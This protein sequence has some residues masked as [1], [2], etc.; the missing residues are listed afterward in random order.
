MLTG[1][2]H[3]AGRT[4]T[5][6]HLQCICLTLYIL[7]RAAVTSLSLLPTLQQSLSKLYCCCKLLE[8]GMVFCYCPYITGCICYSV[9]ACEAKFGRKS[10]LPWAETQLSVGDSQGGVLHILLPV[11][12][13]QDF[14]TG[15]P[16]SVC[17]WMGELMRASMQQCLFFIYVYVYPCANCRRECTLQLRFIITKLRSLTFVVSGMTY[18]R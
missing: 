11:A 18:G 16:V 6:S 3:R 5:V 10:S 15:M 2:C 9:T 1:A 14:K 12:T 4:R 13:C 8:P 7:S 17:I